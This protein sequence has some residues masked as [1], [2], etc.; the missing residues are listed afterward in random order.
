MEAR[1]RDRR[2]PVGHGP[3]RDAP[4]RRATP[5]RDLGASESG[6]FLH[7]VAAPADNRKGW[8]KGG[9]RGWG[10][11]KLYLALAI[12]TLGPIGLRVLTWSNPP[13][14]DLEPRT[15]QHGR[16]LF[17]HE[18]KPNDPLCAGGDGV[19]PVFNAS[20]C[21][22]CHRQGGVGGGGGLENNV[23]T[24]ILQPDDSRQPPR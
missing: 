18:F 14:H 1:W 2:P 20:S 23:T 22:A 8:R 24:F 16:E 10:N 21:V 9:V 15:V 12:A 19:G 3:W 13:A 4:N 6:F 11:G 17:V 5:F 7:P